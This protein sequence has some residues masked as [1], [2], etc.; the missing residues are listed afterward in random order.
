[1]KRHDLVYRVCR[2]PIP[3]WA[4]A[5]LPTVKDAWEYCSNDCIAYLEK[6]TTGTAFAETIT[7]GQKGLYG[8]GESH[9]YEDLE[10]HLGL[11]NGLTSSAQPSLQHPKGKF[12]QIIGTMTVALQVLFITEKGFMGLGPC[13]LQLGDEVCILFGGITLCILRQQGDVRKLVG[14][15]Y[16][17]RIMHG[18][19]MSFLGAD[20]GSA[21][22]EWFAIQ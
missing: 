6:A 5:F 14:E 17:N 20:D 16:V 9:N 15:C 12:E 7:L 22:V 21:E 11:E 13:A 18:G 4:T 19:A 8:Q 2:K 3:Q 10:D 1:V